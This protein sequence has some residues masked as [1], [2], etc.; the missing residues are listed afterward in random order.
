MNDATRLK[1]LLDNVPGL[2]AYLD[3]DCCYQL[4]SRSH[5][6]WFGVEP[7]TAVGRHV[8]EVVGEDAW[9]VLKP[10]FDK[11]SA[12][13]TTVFVGW[14]PFAHGG[15]RYIH[16]TVIPR[17]DADEGMSGVLAMI[18]DFTEHKL[19]EK[20]L[21]SSVRR[22]ETVLKTAVDGIITIDEKG[23]IRSFNHGA[24]AQFGYNASEVIGRNISMLMPDRYSSQHDGYL[25]EYL[26]D[27]ESH[28]LGIAREVAGLRKD[29]SEFPL[30]YI[31]GEFMEEGQH[32]FTGFTRDISDRKAAQ[33]EARVRHNQLSHSAR[34]N[35]LGELATS[36]AHEVNQPLTAIVTLSQALLRYMD[37]GAN[38]T[39]RTR[40]VLNK[41]VQQGKRASDVIQNIRDFIRNE[42][43]DNHSTCDTNGVVKNALRFLEYE[44]ERNSIELH[45]DL[46]PDVSPIRASKVQIEQVLVNL[47]QNAVQ[48]MSEVLD[49]RVLSVTSRIEPGAPR[50]VAILISDTGHGLPDGDASRVFEPFFTTRPGGLGQGLSISRNIIER[51][52]GAIHAKRN[53]DRGAT[54]IISLPASEGG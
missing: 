23:M 3:R 53:Q 54:F 29:G 15:R 6:A 13:A 9:K 38:T 45:L 35:S 20:A 42:K 37:Q 51:H 2:I 4:A 17:R 52:G 1:M 40:E 31:A 49:Q 12:A 24:E 43:D 48:S 18:T 32:F 26:K 41:I 28:P 30:E 36:I 19:M 22:A 47:I 11:A 25:R 7:D 27:G 44:L 16:S 8:S 39:D 50:L 14:V 34:L 33:L 21:D 46:N 5:R 10:H